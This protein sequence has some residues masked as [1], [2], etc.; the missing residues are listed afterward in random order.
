LTADARRKQN[1]RKMQASQ[2]AIARDVA[3]WLVF[4]CCEIPKMGPRKPF[5]ANI[6]A[7]FN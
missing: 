7:P 6:H 1:D 2:A 5:L 4:V 3:M